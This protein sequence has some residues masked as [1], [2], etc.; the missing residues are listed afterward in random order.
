MADQKL[1]QRPDLSTSSDSSTIPVVDSNLSYSQTKANLLKE[2]RVRLTNLEG[3]QITGVETYTELTDLPTTGVLLTSYKVTNDTVSSAN[4]G[5]YHWDGAVYVKDADLANGVVA[6]GN[7]DATNGNVVYDFTKKITKVSVLYVALT[8]IININTAT[9]EVEF[10]STFYINGLVDGFG[11]I[12]VITSQPNASFDSGNAISMVYF[13]MV[14]KTIGLAR[15]TSADVYNDPEKTI[16]FTFIP[17][18]K[19]VTSNGCAVA[20]D[21]VKNMSDG[22]DLLKKNNVSILYDN[23]EDLITFDFDTN[24]IKFPAL[25]YIAGSASKLNGIE[26]FTSKVDL[27]FAATSNNINLLLY[28]SQTNTISVED[29]PPLPV[30]QNDK[31]EQIIATFIPSKKSVTTNGF[32]HAEIGGAIVS[33]FNATAQRMV[34]PDNIYIADDSLKFFKDNFT[35]SKENRNNNLIYLKDVDNLIGIDN[36]LTLDTN[37]SA[38]ISIIQSPRTTTEK[39]YKKD[40]SVVVT[41]PSLKSG[42][43]TLIALG[44]S[45]IGRGVCGFTKQKLEGYSSGTLNTLGIMTDSEG[46]SCEGRGGWEFA[47]YI[48]LNNLL[49]G[50]TVITRQTT[51]GSGSTILNPFLKLADAGDKATNPTWCF[52]NTGV[53]VET[54]YDDNPAL[55]NYY[56]FDWDFYFTTQVITAP[57]FTTVALSTNDIVKNS[58]WLANSRLGLEIILKQLDTY[59]IDN[60]INIDVAVVPTTSWADVEANYERWG[61]VATWAENCLTD[62]NGFTFTNIIAESVF[63]HLYQNDNAYFIGG[64]TDNGNINAVSTVKDID[65]NDVFHM[66]EIGF[67]QYGSALSAFL[68]SKY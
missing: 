54:S 2:D 36:E 18:S 31:N 55:G 24:F 46:E 58:N 51:Q 38:N 11:T 39:L 4:N 42:T 22:N 16:L 5:Y 13:D 59:C 28:N 62:L 52:T 8:D 10:P 9:N 27:A 35:A 23:I 49:D 17:S 65:Y 44:D 48:G 20:V 68:I 66:D 53:G 47:N 19:V 15:N 29:V 6:D 64:G 56:I 33:D 63:V 21:G 37:L 34:L 50:A 67:K 26:I 43:K 40:I 3:N 32:K 61:D 41:D 14:T 12:K 60:A 30:W 1:T 25:F 7:T 57:D 45:L